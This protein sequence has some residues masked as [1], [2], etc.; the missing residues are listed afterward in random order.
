M[1]RSSFILAAMCLLLPAAFFATAGSRVG[2]NADI[3][4]ERV[5]AGGVSF[6]TN[7]VWK[8]GSSIGQ[9]GLMLLATNVDGDVFLNGFWKAEDSC[10][11]YNP[12]ITELARGASGVGI[13]FLVVNGNTYTVSYISKEQGGMPAGTHAI[14][15]IVQ[16]LTGAGMS[17]ATTTVW[18]NV[19]SSTNVAQFYIIRCE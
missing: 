7:G 6:A 3:L 13:T 2:G 16:T 4:Y 9:G 17:G 18:H 10:S 8:L 5:G 1:T 11:L 19:S 12:T 14:T 15:N